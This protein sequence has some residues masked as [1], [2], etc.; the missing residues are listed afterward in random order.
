MRPPQ[1]GSKPSTNPLGL[2]FASWQSAS[3]GG[4]LCKQVLKDHAMNNTSNKKSPLELADVIFKHN[5]GASM[6]MIA[7]VIS[8][9]GDLF[10]D[11]RYGTHESIDIESAAPNGQLPGQ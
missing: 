4:V 1:R 8:E 10:D 9:W 6:E 5:P 2:L 7:D 11:H 3:M